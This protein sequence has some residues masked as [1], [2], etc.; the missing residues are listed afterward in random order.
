MSNAV[1]TVSYQEEQLP[2][3]GY[4]EKY[5]DSMRWKR[6]TGKKTAKG[7]LGLP[8]NCPA[9]HSPAVDTGTHWLPTLPNPNPKGEMRKL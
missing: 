8:I 6:K 7:L 2:L 4:Q 1:P 3:R 9:H 5:V